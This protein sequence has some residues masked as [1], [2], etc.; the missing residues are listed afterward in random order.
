MNSKIACRSRRGV[1]RWGKGV[2][3]NMHWQNCVSGNSKSEIGH[4]LA[5]QHEGYRTG[6][7]DIRTKMVG[8]SG[9]ESQEQF[10]VGVRRPGS[11]GPRTE[12]A[13]GCCR[14]RTD[15]Q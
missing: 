1:V 3:F 6:I 8:A 7:S 13:G 10:S 11:R 5:E 12:I 4:A 15:L 14:L 9:L 2:F